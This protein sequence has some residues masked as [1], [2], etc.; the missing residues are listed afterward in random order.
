MP[1]PT[2]TDQQGGGRQARAAETRSRLVQAT[3]ELLGESGMKAVTHRGVARRA[4]LKEPITAYH[5]PSIADL[6]EAAVRELLDRRTRQVGAVLAGAGTRGEGLV[7]AIT[8]VAEFHV[9][10]PVAPVIA[11][12]EFAL[13]AAHDERLG[14][15][16]AEA[17]ERWRQM[18]ERSLTVLGVQD[19]QEAAERF[20]A[21]IDGFALHRVARR[22]P[23]DLEVALLRDTLLALLTEQLLRPAERS[24][25][26]ARYEL[27]GR[28]LDEWRDGRHRIS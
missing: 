13:A 6:L 3:I 23:R 18:T 14:P 17:M 22:R 26:A 5:F 7:D 25:A 9:D 8:H 11:E 21:V 12:F 1:T 15:V 4:G 24:A 20:L 27:V 2:P 28:R 19:P 16:V 10:Q